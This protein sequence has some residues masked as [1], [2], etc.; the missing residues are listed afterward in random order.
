MGCLGKCPI[1][2]KL[3]DDRPSGTLTGLSTCEFVDI[4]ILVGL[5]L[6]SVALSNVQGSESVGQPI[7]VFLL[8]FF[9]L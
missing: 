3:F 1:E 9:G 5:L 6:V 2:K 8:T 4:V 7:D